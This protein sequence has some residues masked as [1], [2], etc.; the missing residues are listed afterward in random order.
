VVASTYDDAAPNVSADGTRLTFASQATGFLE[1]WVADADGRNAVAI[2][3]FHGPPVA[4]WNA[5]RV[6]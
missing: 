2:T 4:R 1:I 5:N 3:N 6:R